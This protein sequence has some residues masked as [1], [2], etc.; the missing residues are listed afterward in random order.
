VHLCSAPEEE[1]FRSKHLS[2]V[3]GLELKDGRRVVVK[4]RPPSPRLEAA[5]AVQ[6][7]VNER[8]F[9]CPAP[10]A[11]PEP[12]GSM[13]ATAETYVPLHGRSPDPPPAAPT[14]ELLAEL[15]TVAPPASAFPAL[16]PPPPW[17]GWDHHEG[18]L[19]PWPDDLMVDMNSTPGPDWVDCTAQRVRERLSR[20]RAEPVIGHIDWEAHNLD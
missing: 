11:G 15:V 19:W 3:L 13:T 12:F 7:H 16:A 14:A 5:F 4:I 2:Q 9:P 17:V 20:V 6:R 10:L 8:G 18:A 1:L